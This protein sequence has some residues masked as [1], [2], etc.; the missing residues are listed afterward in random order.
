[1]IET[2]V[3]YKHD[4]HLDLSCLQDR[5][6]RRRREIASLDDLIREIKTPFKGT[7]PDPRKSREYREAVRKT[8]EERRELSRLQRVDRLL[9]TG[10]VV[11]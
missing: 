10:K 4:I 9:I 2:K 11:L 3:V 5:I 1:M 8:L 6:A 7:Y